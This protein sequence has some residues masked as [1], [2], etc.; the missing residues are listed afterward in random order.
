MDKKQPI[1]FDFVFGGFKQRDK[2]ESLGKKVEFSDKQVQEQSTKEPGKL[3]KK[4][5][6]EDYDQE[7]LNNL[8]DAADKKDSVSFDFVFGGFKQLE[9]EESST[10]CGF[11]GQNFQRKYPSEPGKLCKK[12]YEEDYEESSN[13]LGEEHEIGE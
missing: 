7:D 13:N 2:E 6:E 10:K 4:V 9:K 1:S 11:N 3:C 5:F 8:D 12:V